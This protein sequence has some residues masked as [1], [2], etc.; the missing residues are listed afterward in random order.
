MAKFICTYVFVIAFILLFLFLADSVF[1][2]TAAPSTCLSGSTPFQ[3]S[4]LCAPGYYCPLY[5]AADPVT[6]PVQCSPTDE[7]LFDRITSQFCPAQGLYE[8]ILCEKGKYC[9]TPTTQLEC[10]A[11]SF[12]PLGQFSPIP[13][14]SLTTCNTGSSKQTSF[15]SV[16]AIILA[17][18][19][20]VS[21][22][23]L[24]KWYKRRRLLTRDRLYAEVQLSSVNT[25]L[26]TK[27][28]LFQ[29]LP[30]HSK[31]LCKGFKRAQGQLPPMVISFDNLSLTI[32]AKQTTDKKNKTILKGV[33]GNIEHSKVTAIMGPSG[34]GNIISTHV[35]DSQISTNCSI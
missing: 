20:L 19:G 34:A 8:P 3:I 28:Q 31:L 7:C 33:T 29:D 6:Y 21:L 2:A 18:A 26:Y 1:A 22:W 25:N 9:P 23:Y 16:L 13:C 4:T 27:G 11:G 12:C 10:P 5:D 17:D 32:P 14:D 35:I 30:A 15:A 24:S